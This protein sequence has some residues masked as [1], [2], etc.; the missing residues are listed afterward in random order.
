VSSKQSYGDPDTRKRILDAA[1]DLAAKLG[2]SMRL[3]DVSE[4]AGVSHQGLYLH[5][6]GR[7]ALL[8]GMLPHMV[9][10]YDVQRFH[11]EVVDSPD[12]VTAVER[13]VEFLGRLNERLDKIS[14]VLEEAQHLDAGFGRDWRR[15]VAGL[16]DSIE[17]DVITR[18]EGEGSLRPE[19]SV[20]DATDLFLAITT[21]GTW[22][23]L[24]RELGWSPSEYM[25]NAAR[26][27][28]TSLVAR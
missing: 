12:G 24:T 20:P 25:D 15:R 11:A 23:E 19:W 4:A 14:W 13:M 28:L 2:P 6:K 7:N 10:T 26:I 27:I 9:E 22:R 8:L 1:V 18:L 21:L 17:S 5:F 16:R 3:A